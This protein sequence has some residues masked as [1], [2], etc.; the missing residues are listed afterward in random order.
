M[1]SSCSGQWNIDPIMLP[2]YY[3]EE[4]YLGHILISDKTK[5]MAQSNFDFRF[6]TTANKGVTELEWTMID[7]CGSHCGLAIYK[8]H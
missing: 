3:L 1:Q 4:L 2:W 6:L 7:L 5:N 8:A